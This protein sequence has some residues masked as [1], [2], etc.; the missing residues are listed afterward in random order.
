MTAQTRDSGSST[1]RTERTW[2]VAARTPCL[3]ADLWTDVRGAR[4]GGRF[5][6]PRVGSRVLAAKL[7][8]HARARMTPPLTPPVVRPGPAGRAGGADGRCAAGRA[9]SPAP[10]RRR[11]RSPDGSGGRATWPRPRS[12]PPSSASSSRSS[13][14]SRTGR[15]STRASTS[16]QVSGR[17]RAWGGRTATSSGSPGSLLWPVL[18][19]IGGASAGLDGARVIAA[20]LVTI[21]IVGRHGAPRRRCSA[22]GPGSAPPRLAV[23]NGPLLA[24]GA[25]GRDRHARRRPASACALWF[26]A[27]LWRRDHRAWLVAAAGGVHASRC[28]PSTRWRPAVC[29]CALLLVVLR[30]RRARMD[31]ALFVGDRERPCSGIVLPGRAAAARAASWAGGPTNNPNF[32]VTP[33]DGRG[34]RSSGTAACRSRSALG[35][36]LACRR[37]AVGLGAAAR[38]PCSSRSTTWPPPTGS[39]DSKHAV[40]GILFTLPLGGLLLE[41]GAAN[42]LP[43]V[44][45]RRR[46]CVGAAGAFGV[47]QA[48]RLDHAW[49]DVRP[50]GAVRG[51]ARRPGEPLPHRRRL[52]LHPAACT[53]PARSRDP[54]ARRGHRTA[55]PPARPTCPL[56]RYDWFVAAQGAGQWPAGAAPAGRG[57]RDASGGSSPPA[58]RSPASDAACGFVT[59]TGHVEVVP[60]H[61]PP[62]ARRPATRREPRA[63][64]ARR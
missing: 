19:G 46:S 6:A 1:R 35:G 11:G 44:V 17:S 49:I 64:R 62:R 4:I 28:W 54:W 36:W 16:R 23:G 34:S 56:C 43:G 22:R 58:R 60:Q 59:W 55:S 51:R 20:L 48:Q 63:P 41:P 8:R 61:P 40:F 18:A 29:R 53:R 15:P 47:A 37:K 42:G 2:A 13:S 33:R 10:P 52:A 25:P 50:G 31:L 26:V 14:P 21:A 27:E 30:G 24:L 5:D 9:A 57:L 3:R 7:R 12:W 39:G 32:G 38:R 45:L